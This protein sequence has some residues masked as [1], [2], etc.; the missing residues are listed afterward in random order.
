MKTVTFLATLLISLVAI[1]CLGQI[2]CG[3]FNVDPESLVGYG[4]LVALLIPAGFN[5]IDF[6]E[7]RT[8]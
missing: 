1:A 2:I 5:V 8:A 3:A 7:E 4:I 6:A